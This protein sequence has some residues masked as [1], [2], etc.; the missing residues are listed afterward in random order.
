MPLFFCICK[1]RRNESTGP[2]IHLSCS[3]MQVVSFKEGKS[4][5][6]QGKEVSGRSPWQHA[7][8]WAQLQVL[9]TEQR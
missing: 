6:Q 7:N 1:T 2:E 4:S 9:E 5:S 8:N 3:V